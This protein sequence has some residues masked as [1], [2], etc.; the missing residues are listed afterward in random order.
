MS[1]RESDEHLQSR[2]AAAVAEGTAPESKR[3]VKTERLLALIGREGGATLEE[4][5]CA[6]GWMPHTVRA[7]ITG[8]RKRGHDIPCKRKDGA[9]HYFVEVIAP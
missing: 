2:K 4:L 7:A 6:S 3:A 8:L 9:T 5:A 1:D